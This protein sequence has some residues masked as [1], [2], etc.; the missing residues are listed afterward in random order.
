MNAESVKALAVRMG[1]RMF[2]RKTYNR[3]PATWAYL[4]DGTRIAYVQ[5]GGYSDRVSSV[6]IPAQP[7]GTGYVIADEITEA[8]VS[9]ALAGAPHWATPSDRRNTRP[10]KDW[11]A[12]TQ[13]S[14]FNP[15][16]FEV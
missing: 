12:F 7:V 9:E 8:T 4:T 14:Q 3:Q 5:W 10:Y 11:D 6:H 2:T 16:Y 15:K 1:L 13:S